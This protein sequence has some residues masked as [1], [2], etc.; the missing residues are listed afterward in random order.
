M[1]FF[2]LCWA[3]LTCLLEGIWGLG[4]TQKDI[5]FRRSTNV[6]IRSMT[7]CERSGDVVVVGSA[8]DVDGGSANFFTAL[9]SSTRLA[10]VWQQLHGTDD[11]DVF[12]A[13]F[14]D[15]AGMYANFQHPRGHFSW[16]VEQEMKS[17]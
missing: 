11:E 2:V 12:N 10:V 14:C 6:E 5:A 13:V 9:I 8:M 16:P 17:L 3:V 1:K 15:R 7:S 4:L